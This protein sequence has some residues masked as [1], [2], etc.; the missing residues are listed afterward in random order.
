MRLRR[1]SNYLDEV[2]KSTSV[3]VLKVVLYRRLIPREILFVQMLDSTP[4][5]WC[6][7]CGFARPEAAVCS[8]CQTPGLL[9]WPA[10]AA[11]TLEQRLVAGDRL[12]EAY[13]ALADRV[14]RGAEDAETC[15]RLA[16]LAYAFQDLRAVEI[17]CHEC[18]RLDP[19]AAEPHVVLGHVFQRSGRYEE[20]AEEYEAALRG[21]ALDGPARE[22]VERSLDEARRMIPEF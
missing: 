14:S 2:G 19:A 12:S 11:L 16:W 20:A 9:P 13:A 17:W 18:A 8:L 3:W 5:R 22:A 15:L 21:Q 7:K 6:P 4:V 10:D 1:K